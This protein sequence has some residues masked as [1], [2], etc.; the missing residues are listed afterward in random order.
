MFCP[1]A[2][3]CLAKSK[4]LQTV[5]DVRVASKMC[6][7]K[8]PYQDSSLGPKPPAQHG[9]AS[10]SVLRGERHLKGCACCVA[11]QTEAAC[12]AQLRCRH[13]CANTALLEACSPAPAHTCIHFW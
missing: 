4:R 5:T 9:K 1:Y 3:I 8:P 10:D 12:C 2:Q 7:S 11:G 13:C 6:G